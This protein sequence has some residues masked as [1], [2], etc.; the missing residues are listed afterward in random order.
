MPPHPPPPPPPPPPTPAPL[1]PL[2]LSLASAP[3]RV[4]L[5]SVVER[6]ALLAYAMH[7]SRCR[8]ALIIPPVSHLE[9]N[10]GTMNSQVLPA[11]KSLVSPNMAMANKRA[12]NL[13]KWSI[14]DGL[15]RWCA[16]TTPRRSLRLLTIPQPHHPIHTLP[17]ASPRLASPRFASIR[18]SPQIGGASSPSRRCRRSTTWT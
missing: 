3:L 17:L 16:G 13:C 6:M 2:S 1:S 7:S 10:R 8:R 15:P 18:L 9:T 12:V 14:A 4:S 11:I 5:P